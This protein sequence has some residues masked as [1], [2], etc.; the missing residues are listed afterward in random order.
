MTTIEF[1][2]RVPN[3]GPLSSVDN[4]VR[5]AKSAEALGFDTV[6]VHDHIVWSSEM[7][8]HHISSGSKEAITEDQTA[9]FYESL[10]TLAFLAGHTE[11]VKLGVACIVM[12]THNPIYTAKQ[13]ATIDHLTNGRLIVGVGLGSRATEGSNEF[14]VFQVPFNKRAS[15]TDEY[16]EV[17]KSVWTQPL[18]TH[19]GKTIQFTDAEIFPKPVQRPHPPIWVGGW[20]DKAAART[21][22]VGDGWIP[23]WL[24]P[25]EMASGREVLRTTAE[26]NGRDPDKIVIAVEKLTAIA[27]TRD[28]ALKRALPTVETSS[29]TYERDVNDMDFAMQR[30][31]FG[32]VDDVRNR[33][34][35]YVDAGVTHFELKLMYG[36]IDEMEEQM[37]LWAETIMPEF[38]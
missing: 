21:G 18:A 28:E 11:R 6:W 29:K 16:I 22:R 30:H 34:Q 4:L 17:M 20:T 36:S 7:H 31:I 5:T 12:P 32:S 19:Q 15:L 25:S 3:S 23:G 9:D 14:D 8:R 1:G 26:E 37:Q 35:S 10:S 2:I 33:V 27:K 24:S 13:T 38:R